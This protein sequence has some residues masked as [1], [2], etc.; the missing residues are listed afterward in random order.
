MMQLDGALVVHGE[1]AEPSTAGLL[2]VLKRKAAAK[3]QS[4]FVLVLIEV[5]ELFAHIIVFVIERHVCR[6]YNP[7]DF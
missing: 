3:I 2:W 6:S 7:H 4:W 1:W 5:F